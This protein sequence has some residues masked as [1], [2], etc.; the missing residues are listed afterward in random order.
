[1]DPFILTIKTDLNGPLRVTNNP[2]GFIMTEDNLANQI[3]VELYRGHTKIEADNTYTPHALFLQSNGNYS[4]TNGQIVNGNIVITLPNTI[5][6]VEGALSID[7]IMVKDSEKITIASIDTFVRK[8][9]TY[10]SID[11][12]D[13][14]LSLNASDY[15]VNIDNLLPNQIIIQG[16]SD[17][18][19]SEIIVT[20]ENQNGNEPLEIPFTCFENLI[21]IDAPA[22]AYTDIGWFIYTVSSGESVIGNIHGYVDTIDL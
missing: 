22:Y 1:M 5:Y 7:V 20:L 4:S 10:K 6:N 8:A 18:D 12:S 17:F 19:S 13:G 15:P 9:T 21:T 2:S 11:F 3:V 16:E 14:V